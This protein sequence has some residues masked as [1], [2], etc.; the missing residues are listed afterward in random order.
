MKT[1][2]TVVFLFLSSLSFGQFAIIQDKDSYCNVRSSPKTGNNITD[3]IKSG[4]L[5]F[6]GDKNEKWRR[7]NYVRNKKELDG[8]VY[9]DRLKMISDYQSIPR[10]SEGKNELTYGKDSI[11]LI[12]TQQP[13]DKSKYKF[14]YYKESPDWIELING[15]QYWGTDGEIPK[16]EYKSIVAF[17]GQ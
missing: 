16:L 14:T 8:H 13:F 3:K 4:H 9:H 11:K 15:K 1:L 2:Q 12:I 17:I 6:A 7:I 5:V 10:V